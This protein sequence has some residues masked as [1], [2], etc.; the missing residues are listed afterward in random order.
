VR[1]AQ[2]GYRWFISRGGPLRASDGTILYWVGVNL[3]I[4]ELKQAEFFLAEGERLAHM[5]SWG[6]D[7]AG[8]NYWSPELFRIHGLEPSSTAPT[9]QK[10]LECVH[11]EDREFMANLVQR[12]LAEP[13]QFDATKRI[14]RPDREVRHIRC[15]G[16][17]VFE[18]EKLLRYVGGAMDVTEHE[19]LTQELRHR[20][21]RLA[22]AQK[23]SHTGSFS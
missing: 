23:L 10:Y 2:G 22:E 9:V 6:L 12:I 18:N 8:F 17:P 11:P 15:V 16:A 19:L 20:E 13:S 3:D 1:D 4:E 21:A 5:G 14:V 7:A